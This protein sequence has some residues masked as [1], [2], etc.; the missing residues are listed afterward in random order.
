MFLGFW[1]EDVPDEGGGQ[2]GAGFRKQSKRQ[3]A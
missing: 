1:L 2:E 3:N